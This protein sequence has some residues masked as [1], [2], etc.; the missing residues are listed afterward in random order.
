MPDQPPIKRCAIY[1]RSFVE[2]DNRDPFDSVN[3]QFLACAEFIGSQVSR[4]WTL[5]S[6]LYEDRGYSG[7][8]L[9]RQGFQSLLADI[10]RGFIDVIVVH[11]LDRLT[12]NLSDFQQ[13][14]AEFNA[15]NVALVSVTQHLDMSHHVGRLATNILTS[16]T[17]FE[18][19]MVG[20]RVKEKRAATLQNGRWQGTSCPLG[21]RV[22]ND[23]LVVDAGESAIVQ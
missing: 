23:Q 12:R 10:K 19:E 22:K 16:F 21:Y 4:N 18:R 8:H 5:V 14:I 7:S 1:S 2:K 6:T 15:H 9:R 3:A 20:Q 11:R 13:I 17:E